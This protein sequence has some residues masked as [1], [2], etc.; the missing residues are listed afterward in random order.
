MVTNLFTKNILLAAIWKLT[1]QISSR[2]GMD[3]H[4]GEWAC[5]K[6]NLGDPIYHQIMVTV[7]YQNEV[8]ACTIASC[9]RCCCHCRRGHN[10]L[11]G[12]NSKTIWPTF[13]KFCMEVH[14][15][16]THLP[17]QQI[18]ILTQIGYH[19]N[20]F[21]VKK[22]HVSVSGQYLQNFLAKLLQIWHEGW[23]GICP[24]MW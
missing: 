24:P 22:W 11:F 8:H 12:H 13:F 20:T 18:W 10:H 4:I 14:L 2:F 16:R 3:M 5:G 7:N 15:D 17:M 19:G 9:C 23:K 1:D 6:V 21:V